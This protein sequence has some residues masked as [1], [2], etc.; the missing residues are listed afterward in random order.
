MDLADYSGQFDPEFGYDK[1]SKET[2]LKLFKVY[3]KFVQRLDGFWYVS[4]MNKCGNDVAFECDVN[5]W[6]GAQ[7]FETEAVSKLLNITGHDVATVVK[8]LQ[9]QMLTMVFACTI[10]LKNSNHAVLTYRNCPTLRALE[11]EG[12]G[13]EKM[14]CQDWEPEYLGI[15]AHYFNPNIKVTPVKV[16]PRTDLTTDISCIWEMKLDPT[17]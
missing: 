6:R 15:I 2:L 9:A 1:L 7:P 12:T 17:A 11:K 13:R 8:F 14:I 5:A 10:D 3:A 16:P 4:V